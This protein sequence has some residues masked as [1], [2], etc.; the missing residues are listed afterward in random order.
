MKHKLFYEHNSA[1]RTGMIL[2]LEGVWSY[3]DYQKALIFEKRTTFQ[4]ICYTKIVKHQPNS[5]NLPKVV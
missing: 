2:D 1:I 5:G 4:N 3:D